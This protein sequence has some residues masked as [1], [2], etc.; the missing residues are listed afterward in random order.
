M[1]NE[2]TLSASLSGTLNGKTVSKSVS[3]VI[4]DIAASTKKVTRL[5]QA[6]GNSEEAVVLGDLTTPGY[7]L[8]QNLDATNSIDLK[9]A[10][11]GAIFARLDPD[12]DGDGTGGF[13]F[14]KLGSG[15]TAPYAVTTSGT[16]LMEILIFEA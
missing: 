6:V 3:N 5:Q 11:G 7:A 12:S 10:T 15:A 9:V 4:K 16:C 1:A 14:L 13:A 8:F 2:L